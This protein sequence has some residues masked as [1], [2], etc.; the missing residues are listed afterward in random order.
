MKIRVLVIAVF[1]FGLW[2]CGDDM[3]LSDTPMGDSADLTIFF[4]NDQH[5]RI[6]NFSKIKE[7]V[8]DAKAN[9]NAILV[10][11]GD[12]FSGNPIVD[13]YR[14]PGFPMIDIMNQTGFDVGVLG[15]HEF[16]FG[17]DVLESRIQ[18]AQF[19]WIL[20]NVD[21]ASSIGSQV[22]PHITIS[23]GELRVTFLG[24]VETNGK[25]GE[26][27][28]STHPLRVAD[29][30]FQRYQDVMGNYTDLKAQEN[31]DLLVALTHLGSGTD[32]T[33]ARTY[34]FFDLIIGG[35]SHEMIDEKVNDIPLVQAGSNLRFLG[36]IDLKIENQRVTDY[37]VDMI[38]LNAVVTPESELA[39]NIEAYNDDPSFYTVV[40]Q[41][42]TDHEFGEV[43][44]FYTTALQQFMEVD[45]TIQNGGG[46]RAG[47][48][49]GPIT[50]LEV[51]TMD[52]FN[53]QSVAFTKT[54]GDFERFFC[55]TGARFY[56]TGIH[57]SDS[58]GDF[59]IVDENGVPLPD[60]QELTMGVNDYIP[61]IF[62]D[63]F[64]F[65]EADIRSYT[66][67]EAIIGYLQ[68]LSSP[69]DF[70]DCFQS[71]DCD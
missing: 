36:R 8:D 51:F 67:A 52:P 13:Q 54:V 64:D 22:T 40:G 16:D 45:F 56:F 47:I 15:N 66:T 4:V 63:Y 3:N 58:G 38:N 60:D 24:L 39:A 61:A 53:N 14:E 59:Q 65:A 41:S 37:S 6:N 23:V 42:G 46:I 71:L 49:E 48:D 26:T 62:D 2:G 69:V 55:E 1:L 68:S 34:P 29:L 20:A 10:S 50:R 11:A 44:C 33:L 5:G 35:H 9:G 30:D 18:E 19:P 57:V 27:I 43:G 28:P 7:I 31:A 70:E 32:R 21:P 17:T 12:I 25:D